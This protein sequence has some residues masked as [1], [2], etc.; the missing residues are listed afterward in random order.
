LKSA[1]S[2]NVVLGIAV[3]ALIVGLVA[4]SMPFI[5][6]SSQNQQVAS[7]Q[8]QV[9]ELQSEMSSLSVVDQKP[10]PR[11]ITMEWEATL[12][13]TQDRWFP[14]T[15]VLN[16]GDT[17][18]LTLEVND[19]DGAH[20]FTIIAP[21][22]SGGVG[23]LTQINMSMIGQWMYHPPGEI[24]PQFGIE[25]TGAPVGCDIMGQNVTC[26]TSTNLPDGSCSM[27]G[28]TIA[29]GCSINGGP[30]GPCTG[31]WMLNK[32]QTEIAEI[33]TQVTIGPL[34]A[35]GVYRFFCSYHQYIGMIGWLII[36]PNRGYLPTNST[37]TG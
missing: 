11:F 19:T 25:V 13:S 5:A 33:Q 37:M 2:V 29:G 35:P 27:S 18:V 31:S 4:V 15:I 9:N 23:Q 16:Q 34:T 32:T 14:Q 10:V 7:L 36:L 20:T 17:L 3:L 28:C 21:T 22:G 12:P 24:G 6:P 1:V 26:N 8:S 30:L